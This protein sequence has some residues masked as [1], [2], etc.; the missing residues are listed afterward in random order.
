MPPRL[1]PAPDLQLEF[2]HLEI[3]CEVVR[4]ASF[5]KASERVKLSQAAVSERISALEDQF[6]CRLLDRS[7]RR[8]VRP[9]PIGEALYERAVALLAERQRAVEELRGLLGERRDALQIGASTVPGSYHLPRAI[10]Q[11]KRS[12]PDAR[13]VVAIAGSEQVVDWVAEGRVEVGIAGDPAERTV[14]QLLQG[15]GGAARAVGTLWPDELVLAVPKE[16]PFAGRDEVAPEELAGVSFVMREPGS[17]TRRWIE[18][19]LQ[20]HLPGGVASLQIAAELGALDAV[21][22]AVLR[23]LGVS[24]LSACSIQ[25]EVAAGLMGAVRITGGSLRRSFYVLVADHSKSRLSRLFTQFLFDSA[26]DGALTSHRRVPARQ[27]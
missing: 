4:L 8:G 18:L 26:G 16:H 23:G 22:Q 10:Q 1:Q 11:F 7:R 24:I 20:R 14:G 27:H 5:S 9:T 15:L 6:G 25:D 2:R 13:V 19:Y 21:K 12:Y 3:F 17:G